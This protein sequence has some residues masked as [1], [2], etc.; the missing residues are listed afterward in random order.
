MTEPLSDKAWQDQRAASLRDGL[1]ALDTSRGLPSVLLPYQAQLLA[2]TALHQLVVIEKSRRI[3]MTWAVAADAVLSGGTKR[4]AGGMDVLY[5][6]YNL[7]MA[8][9]FI[10]TCAMWA[11]AFIPAASGV[12]EFL[13]RDQGDGGEEK[14][15]NAFRIKFASGFE[16]VALTSKPRS[17]RGRQGY[18]IFDEAAFHDELAELLKAAMALLMWGGKVLVI[19]THDGADNP[20]NLLIRDINAGER[21]GKVVRVTFEEAIE[22]GLYERIALTRGLPDTPEAKAEWIDSILAFYGQ[23]ADE[24]LHCIPKAGSGVWLSAALIEARMTADAPVLRLELPSDFLHRDEDARAELLRPFT[25]E[26]EAVLDGLDQS[27][28]YAAGFDFARVADLS[29]LSL[30]ALD[31]RIRRTEALSIEMRNVPGQE[32]IAIVAAALS[33]VRERLLGAA[34]DATGMGWIVAEE[35]GRRFGMRE[36]ED[37]A[38]LIWAIKFSEEWYRLH[39]PPLKKGFE[40]GDYAIGRDEEHLTDLRSVREIRGVARVPPIRTGDKGLRRHGDYAIAL[41]LAD[42]A[43][44]MRW[45][46]YA[47]RGT[48]A[49]ASPL[50]SA[51]TAEAADERDGISRA[52][53]R[54]PLGTNV[55]GG[56]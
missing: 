7:D 18:V 51:D 11:R 34:F 14:Y 38:G 20:F 28:H 6:G 8:R 43:S 39:M 54:T 4:T 29:V 53:W 44:R 33:A 23:D 9:E 13:F 50:P 36:S 52:W 1:A 5:I 3:G 2:S 32:Q 47:Y 19:S 15:I 22:D 30:L 41:A 26:L 27:P 16:I 10:D 37:S 46:D 55:R 21:R 35:M 56:L 49:V 24:E 12:E 40:D 42:F 25:A 45:I 48:G 17:L 31:R